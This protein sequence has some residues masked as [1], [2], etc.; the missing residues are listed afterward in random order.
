MTQSVSFL[1]HIK[2]GLSIKV[3]VIGNR[4]EKKPAMINRLEIRLLFEENLSGSIA[5]PEAEVPKLRE[6]MSSGQD[7]LCGRVIFFF[8]FS[9]F[10][11][12]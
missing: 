9:F 3:K 12:F 8:S 10:F 2:C 6:S 5:I 4:A 1:T 11:I 7:D